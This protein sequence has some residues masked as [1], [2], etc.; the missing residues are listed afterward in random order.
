MELGEHLLASARS[1]AEAAGV[2]DVR[3][4]L[5]DGEPA[6]CILRCA[7]EEGSDCIVLGSRGLGNLQGMFLGSVSHKVASRAGCTCIAV[8]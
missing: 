2:R 6:G 4:R 1:D 8:K 7:E 5:V 3:T